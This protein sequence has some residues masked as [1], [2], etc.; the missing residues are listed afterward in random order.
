[1]AKSCPFLDKLECAW[2]EAAGQHGPVGRHRRAPARVVG[3]E[4]GD[5]MGPF[6]LVHVDHYA[7]ERA[8]TRHG[9]TVAATAGSGACCRRRIGVVAVAA[10]CI[11]LSGLDRLAQAFSPGSGSSEF[12]PDA[13]AGRDHIAMLRVLHRSFAESQTESQDQQDPGGVRRRQATVVPGQSDTGRRSALSGLVR[14][15]LLSSRPQVRVLLGAQCDVA[16]HRGHPEPT[17]GFG[18]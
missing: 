10:C 2:F 4:V 8:D 7:V 14:V 6:V 5:G 16:R 11:A 17:S 15:C 18:V 13:A 12:L 3:M 1:V 9:M